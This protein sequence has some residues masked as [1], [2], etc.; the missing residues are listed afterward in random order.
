MLVTFN[1]DKVSTAV[2][3]SKGKVE[4][5]STSVQLDSVALVKANYSLNAGE[6]I[7]AHIM[8]SS[9]S[10]RKPDEEVERTFLAP[11]FHEFSMF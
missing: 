2:M 9:Q 10:R 8:G 3:L 4:S 6:V 5:I 7:E 11:A 1:S